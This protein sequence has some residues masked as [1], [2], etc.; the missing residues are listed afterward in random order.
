M[1]GC[2]KNVPKSNVLILVFVYQLTGANF[3]P[4]YSL[5]GRS[6]EINFCELLEQN[7]LHFLL[8]YQQHQGIER[9]DYMEHKQH[10]VCCNSFC[11]IR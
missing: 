3:P 8:P 7:S 11:N 10:N 6:P 4:S 9:Q 2:E 5:L 1:H